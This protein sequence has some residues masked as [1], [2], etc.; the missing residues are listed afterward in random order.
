VSIGALFSAQ[1]N[2]LRIHISARTNTD[3]P[4]LSCSC[5]GP[6]Q[7]KIT[8]P[9][10]SVVTASA[11][12]NYIRTRLLCRPN[13][14]EWHL[15]LLKAAYAFYNLFSNMVLGLLFALFI[16]NPK[17]LKSATFSIFT[18]LHLKMT[19]MFI[20]IAFVFLTFICNPFYLQN[21]SKAFSI[22]YSPSA[23][24]DKRT[25][26]SAK[27]RKKIYMVAISKIYRL[28]GAIL[29]SLKY[30]RRNG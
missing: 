21:K 5:A 4:P 8:L 23:L 26:S 15:I 19:S 27:A 24:W 9:Y 3:A 22:S 20:Y 16:T 12:T 25:A 2:I 6:K 13:N 17:Y 14:L 18:P 10:S 1:R 7:P 28:L 11:Y 30:F 29:C